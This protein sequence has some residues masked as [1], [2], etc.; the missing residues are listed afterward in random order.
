MKKYLILSLAL[1]IFSDT[2]SF[3]VIKSPV[4]QANQ[5]FITVGKKEQKFSF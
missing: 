1:I 3:S 2:F 5:I 4:A